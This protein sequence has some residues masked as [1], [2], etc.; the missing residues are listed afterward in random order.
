MEPLEWLGGDPSRFPL[1]LISNQPKTRLHSQLDHGGHS[2]AAKINQ[3]EP[4][5][6]HPRDAGAR[7]LANGDVVRIFNQRGA[8]LGA[9]VI[10]DQVM[11]GVAQMSTGAWY[12]PEQP[13]SP[14]SLCK[15]GNPNLLT[16]D[17]GS[18]RLAQGPIAHTCLVEIERYSGPLP[19]ITAYDPP[20]ILRDEQ[21]R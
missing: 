18:S 2:R 20:E 7:N 21:S 17:I 12:D 10:D 11:P 8:C 4:I 15:H 16:P 1:H 14:G 9:V 3:R 5:M 13:A 6:L 19:R